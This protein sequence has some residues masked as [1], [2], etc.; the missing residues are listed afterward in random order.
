[1]FSVPS[2][3]VTSHCNNLENIMYINNAGLQVL[4][5]FHNNLSRRTK[6]NEIET[7]E[8]VR[9]SRNWNVRPPSEWN[10]HQRNHWPALYPSRRVGGKKKF[11]FLIHVFCNWLMFYC[12]LFTFVVSDLAFCAISV[13]FSI[14]YKSLEL[15]FCIHPLVF[16]SECQVSQCQVRA[17]GKVDPL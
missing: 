4:L 16:L 12:S 7:M 14:L 10:C 8:T 1:M 5:N 11:L 2:D 6:R 9:E 3:D 17:M 15:D 13:V